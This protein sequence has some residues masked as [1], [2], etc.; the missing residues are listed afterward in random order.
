MNKNVIFIVIAL[1]AAGGIG[2]KLMAKPSPKLQTIVPQV[3]NSKSRVK[4]SLRQMMGMGKS[5][6]CEVSANEAEGLIS[7]KVNISG[8]K[9]MGDFKMSDEMGKMMDSH[10]I[11]DGEFTYIWSSAAPQGTKIKN[12]TVAP[13]KS[14]QTQNGFD[15]DQE[16]DMECSDWSPAS[17][18][19]TAPSDVEFFDMSNMMRGN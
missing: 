14:G 3:E 11:N 7:G 9:M 1:L 18:S 10:M 8:S 17:N 6:S 5:A 15:E 2:Y 12:D 16:V 4:S 19:F 13:A